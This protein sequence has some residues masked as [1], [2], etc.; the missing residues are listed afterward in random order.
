MLPDLIPMT[1]S[2]QRD[3]K[4]IPVFDL[5]VG[6]REFDEQ[7]WQSFINAIK[8]E[9]DTFLVLGGD[10]MDNGVCS[11]AL[12]FEQTM[13][14]SDQKRYLVST[15]MPV[16]DK[17]LCGCAGNHEY[18]SR[19]LDDDCP[20][21]DVFAKMDIENRFRENACF[22]ILRFGDREMPSDK[23]PCYTVMVTHGAGGGLLIGAGANRQE[24]IAMAV[25]N[26]DLLITG[27]THKPMT[28][29]GTKLVIDSRNNQ[30]VTKRYTC[31]TATSW[32]NYGGYALRKMLPPGG[33]CEQEI[34]L[35]ANKKEIRVTI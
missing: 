2:F 28:F 17:I 7:R 35:K 9:D 3:I 31:V 21:Y 1:H 11:P 4:L 27:H 32:L 29:P 10:L 5:H 33:V 16:R 12:P 24:R 34:I 8:D 6:S 15:L 30:V 23:R 20:L 19:K 18:R 25:D 13:R 26:L 22:L 14:P